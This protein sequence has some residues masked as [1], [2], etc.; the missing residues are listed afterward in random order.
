MLGVQKKRK[1]LGWRDALGFRRVLARC[2]QVAGAD[3]D[4]TARDR[5]I[6]ALAPAAMQVPAQD[7]GR[8][9]QSAEHSPQK[10]QRRYGDEQ[11]GGKHHHRSF[12]VHALPGDDHVPRTIGEPRRAERQQANEDE[13]N[14]DADHR[15]SGL[16]NAASA[17]AA[18]CR[19]SASAAR[20]APAFLA[21]ASVNARASS[22]NLAISA[23]A[24]SMSPRAASTLSR[25]IRAAG[26]S[27]T[28]A[29]DVPTGVMRTSFWARLSS[30]ARIELLLGS[31]SIIRESAGV[32]AVSSRPSSA[33]LV[34]PC[35][36]TGSSCAIAFGSAPSASAAI[37]S[38]MTRSS[39]LDEEAR[40]ARLASS[41]FM[42]F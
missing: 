38:R 1:R 9:Q 3:R 30:F 15:D 16:A 19:L 21:H 18:T 41:D 42:A 26:S 23:S 13:E 39:A 20:R 25:A 2:D 6:S 34:N 28:G 11:T 40:C 14:D 27:P 7:E 33:L 10:H 29:S 8:P 5:L 12:D 35:S 36:A 17:S 4:Q 31:D 32:S 22:G 37:A 24:A